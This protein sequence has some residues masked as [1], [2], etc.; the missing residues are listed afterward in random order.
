MSDVSD[1]VDAVLADVTAAVGGVTTSATVVMAD[2][3]KPEDFPFASVYQT[4]YD[5]ERLDWL[6]ENRIWTIEC[7]LFQANDSTATAEENLEAMET[8]LEA[9]RDKVAED[10]TLGGAAD[11][12][13]CLTIVHE[14]HPDSSRIAALI[15]VRA[16]KVA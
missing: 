12:A 13:T 4:D 3:L 15:V 7:A 10:S 1:I 5:V 14:A 8:K 9:V 2:D 11:Y 6:Q 16:E